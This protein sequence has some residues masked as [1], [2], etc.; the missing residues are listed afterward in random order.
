MPHLDLKSSPV[1][2]RHPAN[3]VLSAKDVPYR[4]ALT[5]IADLGDLLNLCKPFPA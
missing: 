1:V 3:P 5:F 4:S 2:K